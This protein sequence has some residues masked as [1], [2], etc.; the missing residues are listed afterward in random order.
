MSAYEK[1]WQLTSAKNLKK[2]YLKWTDLTILLSAMD[3]QIS[4]N[5][6]TLLRAGRT[7]RPR[8]GLTADVN[9]K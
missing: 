8:Q 6:T 7:M 4:N 5:W 3:L 9:K 2:N 1:D